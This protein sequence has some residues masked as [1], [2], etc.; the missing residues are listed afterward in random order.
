MKELLRATAERA[1]RYL[2]TL[3]DRPV[4]PPASA[5]DRLAQWDEPLPEEPASPE[6]V[7]A[8]LDE[9]GSPATVASWIAWIHSWPPSRRSGSSCTTSCTR[10]G[11]RFGGPARRAC[12][13]PLRSPVMSSDDV[14]L[15]RAG[16]SEADL[17]EDDAPE[18]GYA[19]AGTDPDPV[20]QD[21]TAEGDEDQATP[22]GD[23]RAVVRAEVPED[24]PEHVL[25]VEDPLLEQRVAEL[26]ER[27]DVDVEG[28]RDGLLGRVAGREPGVEVALD[29]PVLEDHELGLEDRAMVLADD[30]RDPPAEPGDL[31]A[32]GLDRLVQPP[33]FDGRVDGAAGRERP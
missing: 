23:G 11:L 6:K 13:R 5:I 31:G 7:L 24:A 27:G 8:L 1:G 30:R 33:L 12:P 15:D 18:P 17:G 29:G 2:Q 19:D 32:G 10:D 9:I 14:G 25:D 20:A 26:G 4:F 22:S 16:R 3:D 21:A 28:A